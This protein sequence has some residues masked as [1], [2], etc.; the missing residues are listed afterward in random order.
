MTVLTITVSLRHIVVCHVVQEAGVPNRSVWY[1]TG[2]MKKH[3]VHTYVTKSS[4][5]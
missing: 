4:L 5:I 3:N 2:R 1:L